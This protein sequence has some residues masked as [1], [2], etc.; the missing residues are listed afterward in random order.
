MIA[1][2]NNVCIDV[3]GVSMAAI[4]KETAMVISFPVVS[5]CST[6]KGNVS[7]F[8]VSLCSLVIKRL[9]TFT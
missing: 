6:L 7:C 2:M 1:F 4:S 8:L 3:N 9:K 5:L